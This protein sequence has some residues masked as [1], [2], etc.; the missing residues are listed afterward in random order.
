[1]TCVRTLRIDNIIDSTI[2]L[3]RDV[4]WNSFFNWKYEDGRRLDYSLVIFF[5]FRLQNN[6]EL[7]YTKRFRKIIRNVWLQSNLTTRV[8][9]RWSF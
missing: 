8:F 1:M 4:L 7:D 2:V 9:Y 3:S 6:Y 5:G